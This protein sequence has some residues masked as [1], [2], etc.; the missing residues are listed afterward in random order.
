MKTLKSLF[1]MVALIVLT[2]SLGMAAPPVF[3][4]ALTGADEV[5]AITTAAVGEA[6]LEVSENGREITYVLSVKDI[7]NPLAAH[8]HAGA[9][10]VNGGPVVGLF[11]GPMKKGAFS[12]EL[13][14]GTIADKN[15]VGP[16]AGKTVADLITLIKSGGAYINVHTVKNPG[17]EIR[18]QVR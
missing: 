4:A 14:K 16:L 9:L 5:P 3:K 2:A 13:A 11:G 17:G 7:E 10:G 1:S 8:I 18:G 15:L 12:G 6:V